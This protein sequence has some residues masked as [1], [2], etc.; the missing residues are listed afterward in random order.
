MYNPFLFSKVKFKAFE[1]VNEMTSRVQDSK[2]RKS[3]LKPKA[4]LIRR[5]R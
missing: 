5:D 1:F 4:K 3:A 2:L